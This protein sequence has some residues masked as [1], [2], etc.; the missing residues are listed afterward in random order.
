LSNGGLL[1][2]NASLEVNGLAADGHNIT[3]DRWRFAFNSVPKSMRRRI[4]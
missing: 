4:G 2:S 3:C 1:R